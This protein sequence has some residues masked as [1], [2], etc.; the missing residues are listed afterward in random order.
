[1]PFEI[2]VKEIMSKKIFKTDYM[3]NI[4]NVAEKMS[5]E[6]IGSM[7]VVKKNKPVGIITERDIVKRVVAGSRN[8]KLIKSGDI[9]TSPIVCV[10]PNE[11]INQVIEKMKKFKIRRFPVV[12]GGEIVGILTNNDISRFSPDMFDIMELRFR[13][14][15]QKPIIDKSATNGVC[16]KCSNYSGDLK[17]LDNNWFC[18]FCRESV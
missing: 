1:M 10:G 3:D 13:M 5:N 9:M 16:E 15:K 2:K 18:G 11:T 4:Q 8:P 14:K 6:R 7:I 12:D 17:I